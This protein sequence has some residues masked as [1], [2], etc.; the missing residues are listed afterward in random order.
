MN[1]HVKREAGSLTVWTIG[2]STRSIDKFLDILS[3]HGIEAII[4]V[5]RLPSSRHNPQYSGSAL[6]ATLESKGIEYVW[7]PSLGG[8]R[9]PA[10]DSPNTR[11]RNAAFRGYAD[12]MATSEF[13]DGFATLIETATRLRSALLCA[14]A[15]WWRCHRSLLAD[16]LSALGVAVLHILD[17]SKAVAHPYTAAARIVNGELSYAPGESADDG[18]P[19]FEEEEEA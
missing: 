8:R 5:R 3:L 17:E 15:V 18:P 4:D 7:L 13:A 19:P 2:H 12:H 10:P 9:T 1:A 14:E 6:S 11:W 16:A